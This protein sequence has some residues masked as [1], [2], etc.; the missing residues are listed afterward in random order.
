[1]LAKKPSKA[2]V[3]NDISTDLVTLYRVLQSHPKEFEKQFQYQISSRKQFDDL[4]IQD[5]ST[6]TDIQKAVRFFYLQ[7]LCFGASIESKSYG[8]STSSKARINSRNFESNI[9]EFHQRLSRVV[10][11]NLDWHKV[12]E[13][14]DRKHTLFYCDPPYFQTAGYGVSFNWSEYEKLADYMKTIKGMMIISIN[15]HPDIQ[16]LFSDFKIIPVK[17]TYTCSGK[18]QA[19]TELLILNK[20]AEEN[21]TE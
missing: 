8:V 6:L 10:I 7:K 19:V 15:N 20:H 14:Y 13:R 11:E 9:K 1:M 2:E 5:T 17:T 3:I 18:Q 21:T 4:K 16:K 12:I